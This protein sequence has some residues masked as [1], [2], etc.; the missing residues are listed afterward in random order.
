[1]KFYMFLLVIVLFCSNDI[2]SQV[3]YNIKLKNISG[4]CQVRT[5]L[6]GH[7]YTLFKIKPNKI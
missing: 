1:M 4:E 2:N 7:F 6:R 3:K 5:P